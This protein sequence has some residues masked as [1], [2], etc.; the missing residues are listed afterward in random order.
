MKELILDIPCTKA[1]DADTLAYLGELGVN[2][3][4]PGGAA[5][6]PVPALVTPPEALA[7]V[8]AKPAAAP[9]PRPLVPVHPAGKWYRGAFWRE[10]IRVS[11]RTL[12]NP[13]RGLSLSFGAH[14][15]LK[16]LRAVTVAVA[17]IL[18]LALLGA[19]AVGLVWIAVA[20]LWAILVCV[21]WPLVKIGL[22]LLLILILFGCLL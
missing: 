21:V 20:L 9:A 7:P 14:P 11:L 6:A 22:V 5:A 1:F 4:G 13:I 16:V 8:P 2:C 3:Q 18:G 15:G 10:P 17:W 12:A 19:V